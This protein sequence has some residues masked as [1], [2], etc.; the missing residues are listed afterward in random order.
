MCTWIIVHE[1]ACAVH[2][3]KAFNGL[4]Q[5]PDSIPLSWSMLNKR[6]V[7]GEKRGACACLRLPRPVRFITPAGGA[8]GRHR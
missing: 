8:S 5:E 4:L 3:C 1:A 2:L 7:V 6:A